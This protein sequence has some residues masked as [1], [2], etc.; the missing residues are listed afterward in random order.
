AFA[1]LVAWLGIT[2]DVLR[3]QT[4]NEA[5]PSAEGSR[6]VPVARS[7][8][9]GVGT[10]ALADRGPAGAAAA[11]A[12]SD[13][14]EALA[15]VERL[16]ANPHVLGLRDD[17]LFWQQVENGRSRSAVERA[18]FLALAYDGTTRR[19]LADLGLVSEEAAASSRAFRDAA[20]EALSAVGPRLQAVKQ[21]P[22]LAR[23]A[24]DP[25]VREMIEANDTLGLLR[26]PDVRELIGHALAGPSA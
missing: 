5:L 7:V 21:D 1:V 15:R 20:A 8:I 25:A 14:A 19:E 11:R 24:E 13:P 6:F 10:W 12:A 4:G 3:T 22:A 2:V 9:R 17:R 26:H 18:S 23:L 16:L